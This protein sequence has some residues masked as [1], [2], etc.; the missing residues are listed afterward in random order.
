M[1]LW[2][3]VCVFR[4]RDRPGRWRV[5]INVRPTRRV[6]GRSCLDLIIRL[7]EPMSLSGLC[8]VPKIRPH[9]GLERLGHDHHRHFA[10]RAMYSAIPIET[11]D[12]PFGAFQRCWNMRCCCCFALSL[13]WWVRKLLLGV[14]AVTMFAPAQVPSTTADRACWRAGYIADGAELGTFLCKAGRL[15]SFPP[16]KAGT[17]GVWCIQPACT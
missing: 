14:L 17:L 13:R 2:L 9:D 6:D 1:F 10:I 11:K 15:E 4:R 12:N 5:N 16:A 3:W 8:A 7:P